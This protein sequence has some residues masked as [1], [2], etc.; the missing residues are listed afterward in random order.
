[1]GEMGGAITRAFSIPADLDEDL[2]EVRE[3]LKMGRSEFYE[4]VFEFFLDAFVKV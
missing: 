2:E 3:G 1:M 4:T